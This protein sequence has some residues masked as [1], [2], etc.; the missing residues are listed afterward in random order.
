MSLLD[1]KEER[2]PLRGST[3][4][5]VDVGQRTD[6]TAIAVVQSQGYSRLPFFMTPEWFFEVRAIDRLPLGLPYPE[7]ARRVK[8]V[9]DG[10][11]DRT[12]GKETPWLFVDA[13][14]VGTAMVDELRAVNVLARIE[15]VYFNAGDK[16]IYRKQ[17]Q[18]GQLFLSLGKAWLVAR[19]QVLLQ[20]QAIRLPKTKIMQALTDELLSYEIR[21]SDKGDDSY[22]AFKVG[23]HDDLVTALGLAVQV[24]V[25][26]G[27]RWDQDSAKMTAALPKVF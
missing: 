14:G 18:T 16:R 19:L 12:G 2:D 27:G 5:G 15:P 13:T 26:G 21:I 22:G 20:R 7:M 24:D 8:L 17:P 23:S 10:V 4:I 9:V 6:Y 25:A 11:I 3:V 1:G